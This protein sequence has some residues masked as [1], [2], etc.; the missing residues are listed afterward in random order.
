M[1]QFR[2]SKYKAV[3]EECKLTLGRLIFEAYHDHIYR[4]ILNYLSNSRADKNLKEYFTKI[5]DSYNEMCEFKAKI[6]DLSPNQNEYN[7]MDL[8]YRLEHENRAKMMKEVKEGK[9]TFLE[10]LGKTSVIVRGN[11]WKLDGQDEIR[12]LSNHQHSILVDGRIYKNP[13]LYEHILNSNKS[14]YNNK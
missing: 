6:N 13:D 11:A 8:Y 12:K 7:L 10:H 1:L 9:G 3:K 2:T 5:L 14:K 4:I